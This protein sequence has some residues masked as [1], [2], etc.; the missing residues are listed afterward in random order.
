METWFELVTENELFNT[1]PKANISTH[2]Q[3]PQAGVIQLVGIP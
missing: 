1:D 3:I 2:T